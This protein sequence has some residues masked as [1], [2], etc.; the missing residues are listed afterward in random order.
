MADS[1]SYD[2]ANRLTSATVTGT[3]VS[4]TWDG[5][6]TRASA[7]SGG[8]TTSCLY[9]VN[10]GLPVL[11]EDGTRK[12]VWGLGLA[13]A[14][15]SSGTVE[16]YHTDGLGSV[17]ALTDTSQTV[18]ARYESDE[19]GVPTST[20]GSSSQPFGYTGEQ[21]D[22]ATGLVYLRARMY[23]AGAGRFLQRDAWPGALTL[24]QSLHRFTYV[25]NNPVRLVDPTGLK[26]EVLEGPAVIPVLR[27]RFSEMPMITLHIWYAQVIKGYPQ[28][29][30]HDP[31][32]GAADKRRASVCGRG[33]RLPFSCDEYPFASTFEGGS[34][35][36]STTGRAAHT[37]RVP[38]T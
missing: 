16:V 12:Y 9:D 14:V 25:V 24:P 22:A 21:R 35:D 6:G 38:I 32:R 27:F 33:Y 34:E 20:T 18:V 19:F 31:N 28:V 15:D 26:S 17:R 1:F 30:T 36:L 23:E 8:S 2:Q 3:A 4:S 10:G 29:L 5:D 7:T 13:Y 11:L 37:M